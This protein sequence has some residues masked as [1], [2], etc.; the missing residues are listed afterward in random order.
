MMKFKTLLIV[1]L[2][3]FACQGVDKPKKPKNLISKDKMANVLYDVYVLNAAKGINKNVLE[4]N[5]IRP[6]NFIFKKHNIDSL[7]FAQ[8]NNYYAYNT[9]VYEAIVAKVKER[10]EKDKVTYEALSE[11]EKKKQ[12]SITAAN[13]KKKDTLLEKSKFLKPLKIDERIKAD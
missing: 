9:K 3:T 1:L 6:E 2:L 13:K 10:M 7:Q 12:D 8:S 11:K 5:G 4:S